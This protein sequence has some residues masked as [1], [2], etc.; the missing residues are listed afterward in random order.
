MTPYFA[1]GSNLW[2]DQMAARLGPFRADAEPP[3]LAR[4]PGYRVAFNMRGENGQVYA[5]IVRPGDHVL[6][7]IYS[8]DSQALEKLDEFETGYRRERVE[9]VDESGAS[10]EVV[11]YMAEPEN[12]MDGGKPSAEYVQRILRG[13]RQHGL[14][15]AYLRM[16][17]TLAG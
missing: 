3:R 7:V 10:V 9:V 12:V 4:L 13:G 1:Y 17:E 6:G 15:E 5:N 16:I 8:C 2:I 11:T 14:P